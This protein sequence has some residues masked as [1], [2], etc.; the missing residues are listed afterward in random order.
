M[1]GL[2][3]SNVG[4]LRPTS[5]VWISSHLSSLDPAVFVH[6]LP[7]ARRSCSSGRYACLTESELQ[8]SAEL[9]SNQIAP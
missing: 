9:G 1:R 8:T 6:S 3:K 2:A 7:V 4:L 5:K